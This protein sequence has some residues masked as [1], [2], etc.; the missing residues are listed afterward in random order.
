M[1]AER[2]E[3]LPTTRSDVEPTDVFKAHFGRVLET[4][5]NL[6][7]SRPLTIAEREKILRSPAMLVGWQKQPNLIYSFTGERITPGLMSDF[8][9]P[10][11][12]KEIE[13]GIF[14]TQR[15]EGSR[16][17][18]DQ[19]QAR[20]EGSRLGQYQMFVWKHHMV[21]GASMSSAFQL[22][23]MVEMGIPTSSIAVDLP[24]YT[25]VREDAQA[26][27]PDSVLV[28]SAVLLAR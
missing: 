9:W 3:A 14:A 7:P 15:E 16:P 13:P 26:L 22:V 24:R 1:Q 28:N 27:G 19:I 11:Y 6:E 18:V 25:V 23:G 4:I 2:M 12:L 20:V 17:S 10:K 8:K 5:R 21:Q